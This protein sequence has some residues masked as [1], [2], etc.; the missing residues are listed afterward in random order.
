MS[1]FSVIIPVYNASPWILECLDSV[2]NQSFKDFEIVIVNDGS[3]DDSLEKIKSFKE[4]NSAVIISIIEQENCGLGAARNTAVKKATGLWLAFLD[5]DDYWSGNK[6]LTLYK[7]INSTNNLWFYHGVFERA[8]NGLL[9][10]RN[11]WPIESLEHLLSFG[12]PI[13]PSAC[14]IKKSLFLHCKGFVEER[15]KVEDLGLW[16]NILKDE[17]LPGFIPENLTVYRMG[18]GL[19]KDLKDHLQKVNSA[20]EP[21]VKNGVVSEGLFND[22]KNR[23]SYEVARQQHKMGLFTEALTGYKNREG[24]KIVLLKTLARLG[25]RV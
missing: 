1:Y 24:L 5:A 15:D 19:T 17:E 2:A 25:V 14:V 7:E 3:T 11:L 16:I 18:S 20:V 21:F 10:P 23:K 6:L 22:F 12:N 4:K 8:T 9:R 13:T